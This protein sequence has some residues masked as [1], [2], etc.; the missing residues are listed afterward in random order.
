MDEIFTIHGIHT[1]KD[2]KTWQDEFKKYVDKNSTQFA[3][4]TFKYGFWVGVVPYFSTWLNKVGRSHFSR[5]YFNFIMKHHKKGNPISLV[6]HSF[7]TWIIHDVIEIFRKKNIPIKSIHLLAGVISSHIERN[8][9]DEYL[10]G[11]HVQKIYVWSSKE[12]EI[13]RS[14]PYPFGHVGYWGIIDKIN[15]EDTREARYKP[16]THYNIY[17]HITHLE[18]SGYSSP[19][20]F[21][22]ILFDILF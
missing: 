13:C 16:Y 12:D 15:D 7:G 10:D 11:K 14:A 5:Q 1:S 2:R 9:L 3:C 21:G 17:N 18:H 8:R 20:V 4:H 6:G 19:K 22:Q